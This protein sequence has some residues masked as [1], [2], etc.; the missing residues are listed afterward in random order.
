MRFKELYESLYNPKIKKLFDY[1]GFEVWEV[2]GKMIRDSI[3]E[4]FTDFGQPLRFDFI[5]SNEF[6]IDKEESDN[7]AHFYC[8]HMYKEYQE[9]L[10]GKTYE[11]AVG[12]AEN[13]E[14]K[15]REVDDKGI[16]KYKGK[17]DLEAIHKSLYGACSNGAKIWII[18]GELVRDEFYVDFTQGGHHFVYPWVPID[19]IWLDNDNHPNEQD[20]I[21]LHELHERNLMLKGMTYNDA[22]RDSSRIEYECRKTPMLLLMYLTIEGFSKHEI[23]I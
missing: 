22:H 17:I 19:E 7:E 21:L 9:M 13:E 16:K 12:L 3:E 15:A 10:A 23:N 8:V 5:P 18:D 14:K 6:W 1:N 2:D 11:E 4:E 20:L